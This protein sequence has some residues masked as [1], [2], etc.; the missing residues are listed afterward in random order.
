MWATINKHDIMGQII[1][2]LF[3][4]IEMDKYSCKS[5]NKNELRFLD[6]SCSYWW[7]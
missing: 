6:E 2:C 7:K 1:T 3:F 4:K 5:E